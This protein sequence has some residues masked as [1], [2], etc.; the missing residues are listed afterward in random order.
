MMEEDEIVRRRW[1]LVSGALGRGK[2]TSTGRRE[3]L[4][5]SAFAIIAIANKYQ[6]CGGK[7]LSLMR[8]KPMLG[9]AKRSCARS[10]GFTYSTT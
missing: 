8:D 5:L 4:I 2:E 9:D 10:T 3:A 6:S 7:L 1:I